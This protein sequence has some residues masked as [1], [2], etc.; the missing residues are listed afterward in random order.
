MPIEVEFEQFEYL[1]SK[2]EKLLELRLGGVVV[3][4]VR[5]HDAANRS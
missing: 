2:A 1:F 3:K 4:D 5:T